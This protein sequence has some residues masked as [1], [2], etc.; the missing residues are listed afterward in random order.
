MLTQQPI[1]TVP[2]NLP[3][4]NSLVLYCVWKMRF[5]YGNYTI[6]AYAEPLPEET[7]TANNNFTCAI[8][9]H[10]GVPGD[11]S[12]PTPGVYDGKCG[13]GDI[14]YL[15]IHFMGKPGVG[16]P[17]WLPNCD[18]NDDNVIN[19]RDIAIAVLNFEKIE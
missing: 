16:D 10:V 7:N 3:S 6:S 19:M 11:I 18:I 9:I 1:F 8:P 17:K 12:G 13:M 2:E 14:A 4:G 5:A 15:I